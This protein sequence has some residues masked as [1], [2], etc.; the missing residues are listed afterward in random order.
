MCLRSRQPAASIRR[1]VYVYLAYVDTLKCR[2]CTEYPNRR[3]DTESTLGPLAATL[4]GDWPLGPLAYG[5]T[6]RR[7]IV[8]RMRLVRRLL[9]G[10][11]YFRCDTVPQSSKRRA[12]PGPSEKL[13][14]LESDCSVDSVIRN[15]IN[16]ITITASIQLSIQSSRRS[17]YW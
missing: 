1:T 15:S 8:R 7:G 12:R 5:S 17:A 2:T 6:D 14:I 10:R 13:F 4:R 9:G 16:Q 11:G 3:G